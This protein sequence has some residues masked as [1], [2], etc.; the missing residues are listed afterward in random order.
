MLPRFFGALLLA[1]VFAASIAWQWQGRA[2]Q[3]IDVGSPLDDIGTIDFH[4]PEQGDVTYRWSRPQSRLR[5]Y[6]PPAGA[7]TRITLRMFAPPQPDGPQRVALSANRQSL[8]EFAVEARPRLF[9]IVLDAPADA[10]LEIGLHSKSLKIAG[11]SRPLGVAVDS[12]ALK[13]LRAPTFTDLL[14]ELW[15]APFLPLGV[16]LLAGCALLL[17]LPAVWA[18]G[19]PALGMLALLAAD[20][21][22]HDSRLLLAWYLALGA[23][24]ACAALAVAALVRRWPRILP[25]DD[26]RALGWITA[27]FVLILLLTF[28]PTVRS[29]GIEY[30]AYL[31]SATID[32]DLNFENDY[33]QTPFPS[34]SDKF[35]LLPTGY[36]ENLA[37]VGPAI[38]WAP[39]Y[40]VGHIIVNVGRALG[41]PW[42]A[43]GYAAPYVVLAVFT[44]ALAGLAVM[45]AGYRIAR[46]WAG[47]PEAALAVIATLLGSNLLYYTMREGSFA[48]AL[49][50]LAA[51]LYVL[52]WLRLEERPTV[53]RWAV[54]GAAAGATALMYWIGALVLVLPVF[55]CARL[56]FVA[57]R[58]PAPERA[59]Q[60]RQLVLGGAVAAALLIAA[61]SPQMI[62]WKII[63]GHFIAIPHGNDYIQPRG[64]Q[65]WKLLFS[66][67]YGLLPWTPA[68]FLGLV[69]LP[70]LW[71]R[72]RWLLLCL[73]AG[74][75]LYFGYNASLARWFGG[76]SFGLRR[77]TVLTPWFVIGLALLFGALKRWRAIAP[78]APAALAAVWATM[79][80]VR[81]DLFLIPHVPEQIAALPAPY[82]FLSRDTL[83][84][85]A[86]RGW[87]NNTY[88]TQNLRGDSPAELAVFAILLGI[89]VLSISGLLALYQRLCA[90]TTT[91]MHAEQ[92]GAGALARPQS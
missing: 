69:G 20:G 54:L 21:P 80:L 57:L 58:A 46:R 33:H 29:D 45:L 9:Q 26:R 87:L 68:F 15:A 4:G 18:G 53:G 90:Q 50:G 32:G 39:L 37:S 66:H 76:G 30:Y 12:I 44:S 24:V 91:P 14:R 73:A 60:P 70:L 52:A 16:L 2:Q 3:T 23:G 40:G 55:T 51:T 8:G 64:F 41:M 10:P 6:A 81:Y 22:F 13:V 84:F 86:L 17:R 36:Y 71:R 62:A 65:G 35:R 61:F 85:W 74:F 79:L 82:F 56:A 47:P 34:I 5:L 1:L 7:P 31:R 27:A 92:R 88:V 42:Q 28:T 38:V 25:R 75:A 72:N 59:T 43:D 78:A 11:D 77:F 48:H 49:S 67:L 89:M 83:P 19:L 63:Y